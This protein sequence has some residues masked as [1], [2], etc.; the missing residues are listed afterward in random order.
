[1]KKTKLV[2]LALSLAPVACT[3]QWRDIGAGRVLHDQKA[4]SIRTKGE[5]GHYIKKYNKCAR[6]KNSDSTIDIF[7]EIDGDEI[8]KYEQPVIILREGE[9]RKVHGVCFKCRN[10]TIELSYRTEKRLFHE[11]DSYFFHLYSDHYVYWILGRS[12]WENGKWKWSTLEN[13]D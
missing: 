1:M 12:R 7:L 6:I 13:P 9:R 3:S 4:A 11:P 2:V 5:T 10:G 8:E